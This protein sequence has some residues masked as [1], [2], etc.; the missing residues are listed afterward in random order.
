[1]E[2][3]SGLEQRNSAGEVLD[4]NEVQSV[5]IEGEECS[6]EIQRFAANSQRE[7]I[8]TMLRTVRGPGMDRIN[9]SVG[10]TSS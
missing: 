1:M 10:H 4:V 3:L 9:P 8:L 7:P 2:L 6:I 5:F